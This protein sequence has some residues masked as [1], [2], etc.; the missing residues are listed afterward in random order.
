MIQF[1]A[2]LKKG[3]EKYEQLSKQIW[4][5]NAEWANK[6]SEAYI[7]EKLAFLLVKA[8]QGDSSEMLTGYVNQFIADLEGYTIEHTVFLPLANIS[9]EVVGLH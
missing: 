2:Y 4:R 9:M 3:N 8:A 7:K 5:K 6:F 1:T